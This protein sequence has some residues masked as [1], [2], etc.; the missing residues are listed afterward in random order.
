MD[1]NTIHVLAC[2]VVVD[3]DHIMVCKTVNR[4]SNFYFL[5][6]GHIESKERAEKAVLRE[7]LEEVGFVFAIKRFLGCLETCR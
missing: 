4:S 2:A 1:H 3:Q 7:L 5:P 6:G